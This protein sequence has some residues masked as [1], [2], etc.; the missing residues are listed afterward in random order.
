VASSPR[1][2]FLGNVE[3]GKSLPLASLRENYDAILFAYGAS[4]DRELGI[5]GEHLNGIYSARAFVGWY[6]GLPEFASLNPDLESSDTAVI[7]GQGNVALDVARV[8]LCSIDHLKR[9]DI[10]EDAIETLRRS[11]VKHV[12]VVGRRGPMQAA[13]TIKEVREL[14]QLPGVRFKPIESSL[15]APIDADLPRASKRIAQLLAKH[16]SSNPDPHASKSL[17][18]EF[19]LSPQ[20]FHAGSLPASLSSIDFERNIWTEERHRFQKD[21]RVVSANSMISMDSGLAFRSIGYKA[22][23]LPG[24]KDLGIDFDDRVGRLLN[25]RGRVLSAGEIASG[26]Y[27]A[28]WAKS[29][30]TGVIAT[31]MEDS[32]ATA[33]LIAQ[34]WKGHE[35]TKKGSVAIR[36]W[37]DNPIDWYGWQRIDIAERARG[38]KRGKE[39]EKLRSVQ[40]MLEAA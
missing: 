17:S 38:E 20:E 29:G 32:F 28:G 8:L 12:R 11:R 25:D 14:L 16:S 30:P 31:T 2:G 13:F 26:L 33:E 35:S 6:N 10:S 36:G 5:P 23:A 34:D 7:I 4:K 39:R 21:A 40:E 19:L 24:M 18:L 15:L 1:F 3:I 37:L 22:E 27:C 9:T